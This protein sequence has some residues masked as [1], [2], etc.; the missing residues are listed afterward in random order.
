MLYETQIWFPDEEKKLDIQL[1]REN[2][3]SY[4]E[5]IVST[6]SPFILL[7]YANAIVNNL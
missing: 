4:N 6:I 2:Y 7:W 1:H 5:F 3:V